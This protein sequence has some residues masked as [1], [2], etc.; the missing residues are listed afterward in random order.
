M[1]MIKSVNWNS[2]NK[3]ERNDDGGEMKII[4]KSE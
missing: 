4:S 3:D 1:N 2:K